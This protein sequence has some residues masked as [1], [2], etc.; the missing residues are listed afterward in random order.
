[1]SRKFVIRNKRIPL[2]KTKKGMKT[3]MKM[4]KEKQKIRKYE[5]CPKVE[6]VFSKEMK[7]KDITE[8]LKFLFDKYKKKIHFVVICKVF[9]I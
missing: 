5:K 7:E 2:R 9:K 1:M 6:V 8:M 4:I 3:I